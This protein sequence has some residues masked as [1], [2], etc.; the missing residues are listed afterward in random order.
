MFAGC[1]GFGVWSGYPRDARLA[2]T[3]EV[4]GPSCNFVEFTCSRDK[5]ETAVEASEFGAVGIRG[6]GGGTKH[7]GDSVGGGGT[8]KDPGGSA[9]L[10]C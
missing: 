5:S 8:F 2:V 1:S 7:A 9:A 10:A 4:D 6:R 3:V